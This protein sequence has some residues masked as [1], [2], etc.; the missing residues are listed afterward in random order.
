[1]KCTLLFALLI[2]VRIASFAQACGD[3]SRPSIGLYDCYINIPRPTENP[4]SIVAWQTLFWPSAA[5]RGYMRTNDPTKDCIGWRDGAMINAIDL[6]N[7]K[8]KFGYEYSNL[9]SPGPLKSSNYL[10]TSK[11]QASGSKYIF[12]LVLETAISREVVK[13]VEREFSANVESA[14]NAGEQA[15][16]QMMPLFETIR[17]FEVDKRN[18]DKKVAISDV[19]PEMITI[20]PAKRIV[21]TEETIDIDITMIDCDGVPLA[22]RSIIFVD[23]TIRI[24]D[25]ILLMK[26]TIGGEITP[27]VAVTDESGKVT[28]KFKAGKKSGIAQIVAWYPH[29]KPYG[30]G[31]FFHG[32]ANVQIKPLPPKQWV[33]NAQI[34]STTTLNRD[35]VMAFDMGGLQQVNQS[36]KR[37]QTKS[38]GNIIAVIENMTEEPTK[39]FHYFSDE[40]VPLAMIVTGEGFYDE[41]STHR[42]T[43]DGKLYSAGIRNDNVRGFEI[44]KVDIQF[45][46]SPDYKYFGLGLNINAVGSYTEHLYFD[47]WS[48]NRGD[49]D[50]Y[51]IWCTGGGDALE[52]TNCKIMKSESGYN[53]SWTF[54]KKDQKKSTNGTEYT[55]TEGTIS[56]TLTPAKNY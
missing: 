47:G 52:D 30:W 3:C 45:D 10:I 29:L 19:N 1:M 21:N 41:F 51:S 22:D 23:T 9:P 49:Y 25:D 2:S 17:K 16:M 46:Y 34:T 54:K 31:D 40:A 26:G 50:S 13:T 56:A 33:L 6:Q 38:H 18:T 27:H 20:K 37:V 14:N 43:I 8:L 12:T 35:T 39:S 11:V 53:I 4:D 5:A 15:A 48:D 28:V 44:S 55:I 24:N 42:E 36:S 32:T 7:G